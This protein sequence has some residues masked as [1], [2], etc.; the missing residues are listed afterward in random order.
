[1]RTCSGKAEANPVASSQILCDADRRILVS[2]QML[3]AFQST[4]SYHELWR[5]VVNMQNSFHRPTLL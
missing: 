2:R 3:P 1:M 5:R 4:I